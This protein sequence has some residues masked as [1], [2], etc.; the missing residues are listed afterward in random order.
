MKLNYRRPAANWNEALPIGGGR[1]GA[2]VFGGVECERLQLNEDTLWSGKPGERDLPRAGALL[3]EMRRLLAGE[4]YAEADRLG[5]EM[6]GPYA[7]AYLPLGN[8]RLQFE[9][10]SYAEAYERGL[11]LERSV[12]Y[13]RYQIGGVTY[14]REMFASYPD[15][16]IVLRLECSEPGMLNLRISMDSPLRSRVF[17]EG[18]LLILK[19]TA[20]E[21][22]DPNYLQT[23]RP[24]VYGEAAEGGGALN[25]EG[26]AAVQLEGGT[27]EVLGDGI[28][29]SGATC[30]TVYFSA[31]T[32]YGLSL[33]SGARAGKEGGRT[34][35]AAVAGEALRRALGSGYAALRERHIADYRRLFDRVELHLGERL[36]P[37]GLTTE[38]WI[39][40]YGASDPALVELLYQYGRYLLISSSRPGTQPANLQGIWNDDTRPPWSSNWTLNINTEMNYWPAETCNLPECHEPLLDMIGELAESGRKTARVHYG[41]RGWAA[42]HNTDLWRQTAPA[43]GYGHGDP[44]WALWPMGGVWLCQHLWEHYRFGGDLNELRDR[45]YPLMKEAALFCLDWL[46]EDGNGRLITSPSTSPEHRFV[47]PEKGSD[48]AASGSRITHEDDPASAPDREEE[49]PASRG[50]RVLA[51]ISQASTMDL[52]LIWDLFTNCI[53]AAEA[54]GIDEAF[55]GELAGARDRLLPM[56]I[57]RYGQLQEW[58]ADFEDEDVNHRH[59]SHLFGVYPG[60]QLTD[61]GTP[62]LFRAARRSLERRG[63]EGTGWSLGWKVGLWAR[64]GEGDRSLKLL[65]NLLRLVPSEGGT[66]GGVYANLLDAHPPFQIDGNFG[67]T[68][69]IAEMLLQSHEGGL[70]FLP[71]LP[72]AWPAGEFKGL[73]ARGG[74][75]VDLT[76][77]HGKPVLA[78]I[79]SPL[80]GPCRVRSGGPISVAGPHGE[81][82]LRP[83]G[84][85][86][87]FETAPG[88]TYMLRFV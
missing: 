31:A 24:V 64:F 88:E 72:A 63:D 54:L 40:G 50:Q 4:R 51:G 84:G 11:D 20:P 6:L 13:V 2:M 29:I 39:A 77:N 80:G 8:L 30:A 38:E 23:D 58:S 22:V 33:S 12:A 3:P 17:A 28:Y 41:A 48:A 32:S 42:H 34:D 67:A 27:A 82:E 70:H 73:R 69:G 37:E 26:R 52:Q 16:I 21:H 75:Q 1:L 19:G 85:W 49:P 15:R 36:A 68:A 10:G 57:G 60:R 59:V 81:D 65:S 7:Q 14:R 83:D 9:H 18:G 47:V 87:A 62:E 35:P 46:I 78:R 55:R 25:F 74:F 45:A 5:K 61:G 79:Y 43:G 76:W 66:T 86:A 53:E 44:F 71:A 56:Q